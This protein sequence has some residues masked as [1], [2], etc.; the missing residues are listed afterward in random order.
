MV[1]VRY[2][3]DTVGPDGNVVSTFQQTFALWGNSLSI[4]M[5]WESELCATVKKHFLWLLFRSLLAAAGA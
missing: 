1:M 2:I 3:Q 5:T 4:I